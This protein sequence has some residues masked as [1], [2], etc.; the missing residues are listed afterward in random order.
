M[1]TLMYPP[2]PLPPLSMPLL[3]KKVPSEL[4]CVTYH[5]PTTPL[6]QLLN[7]PGFLPLAMTKA[8]TSAWPPCTCP[9]GFQLW[10]PGQDSLCPLH[11]PNPAG[12]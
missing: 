4:F 6:D 1:G 5:H 9:I 12:A 2:Y 7:L 10:Y 3:L 11:A 8:S